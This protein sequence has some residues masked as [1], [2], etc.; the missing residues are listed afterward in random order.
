VDVEPLWPLPA[1]GACVELLLFGVVVLWPGL[2]GVAVGAASFD[3][4]DCGLL[5]VAV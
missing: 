5:S 2:S 3:P 4:V 1:F